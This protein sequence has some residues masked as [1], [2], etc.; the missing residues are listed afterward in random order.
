M[1]GIPG[2]PGPM[3]CLIIIPLGP[4]ISIPDPLDIMLGIASP[5]LI[6]PW[7]CCILIRC[8]CICIIC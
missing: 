3:P 5:G 4:I 7:C 2:G 8:C 1:P 6:M